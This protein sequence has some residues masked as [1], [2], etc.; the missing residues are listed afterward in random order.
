MKIAIISDIHGN[1]QALEAVLEDI[2][3]EN[4]QK[5]FCLGDLALAGPEPEKTINFIRKLNFDEIIQGNTDELLSG[6]FNQEIY[7]YLTDKFPLMAHA[8]KYDCAEISKD[9]KLFLKNLDKQKEMILGNLK[10]LLVHGSPRKN[11]EDICPDLPIE[12]IEEIIQDT[13]ADLIFCGHTHLPCG[14]QTS[15]KQTVVNVG[16]VGRPF[17][18]TPKACYAILDFDPKTHSEDA[19]AIEHRL[20]EYDVKKA[21]KILQ[22]R[23][24]EGSDKLAKL[25]ISATSRH[26]E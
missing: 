8:Y 11:N 17:S 26:A 20:V 1:I 3:K 19:F 12:K 10:I 9:N 25:L 5:I 18:L 13:D 16:S 2:K 22:S 7:N 21:S 15:T 4:C 6:D 14:Y 24:Y 23:K